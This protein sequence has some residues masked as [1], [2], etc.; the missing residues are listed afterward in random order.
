VATRSEQ[1][2]ELQPREFSMLEYLMQNAG[3]VVTRTML[4]EHVWAIAAHRTR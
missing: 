2:I 3:H 1:V 4:L